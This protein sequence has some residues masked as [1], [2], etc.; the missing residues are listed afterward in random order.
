MKARLKA[1]TKAGSMP[2]R[3]ARMLSLG[4]GAVAC[5]SCATRGPVVPES[6]EVVV[7]KVPSKTVTEEILEADA[8]LEA[9]PDELSN[10]EANKIS[11]AVVAAKPPHAK[12]QIPVEINQSVERWIEFFTTRDRERFQRFLN[13][14]HSYR[15]V[16]EDILE[17]N[18]LPSEL[19]YLAMI[20]SGYAPL[21][22]S[23]AKAKGV[24]QFMRATGKQYGL[25]SDAWVDERKDPI[26]A[27]EAAAKYLKDLHRMFG[28][29]YL[30]MS[31]YNAGE[32]RIQ[33]AIEKAGT[34]DFWALAARRVLPRETTDYVPK[35]LAAVIVGRDPKRFGLEEP[36]AERYPD[37]EALEVPSPM[38]LSDIARVTKVSESTLK[39]V[40]PHLWA[41]MTPPHRK[42]YEVWVPE[43]SSTA[44]RGPKQWAAELARYRV[45][46]FRPSRELARLQESENPPTSHRVL[47]GE[48]LTTIAQRY[49]LSV[50]YLRRINGLSRGSKS[51][52]RLKPGQVLRVTARGFHHRPYHA[53][54][55]KSGDRL[56]TIARKFGLTVGQIKR[57]NRMRHD[58]IIAG[59]T[60]K[61]GTG[62]I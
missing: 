25:H 15:E 51:D 6:G 26:R 56:D 7:S 22:T 3:A 59:Q 35:F 13:R 43:S 34:R 61:I 21:A 40:N 28:S 24:W 10:D 52:L 58:R 33:R 36:A 55:V 47:S 62:N 20:E 39:W 44:T 57:I 2:W 16:V 50:S 37:V 42:V 60:L 8:D 17:E 45:K 14:G 41:G 23:H 19:Y 4:V 5:A 11:G 1:Q 29:W 32:R 53:Y 27:T 54:R 12:A 18:G 46:N 9:L 30:A 31:A 48:N 38:K 49:R